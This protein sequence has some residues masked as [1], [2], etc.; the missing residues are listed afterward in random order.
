MCLSSS[1]AEHRLLVLVSRFVVPGMGQG[2]ATARQI[3]RAHGGDI[4]LKSK[5]HIGTAAY[6]TIPLTA[7]VTMTLPMI[8]EA[9]MEGETVQ[10][11]VGEGVEA[12]W[13]R[14]DEL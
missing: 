3:L 7:D 11:T 6:F 5:L 13:E 8:D 10:L 4:R 12:F 1:S 9:I 14:D 2:L